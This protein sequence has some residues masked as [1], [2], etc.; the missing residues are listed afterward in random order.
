MVKSFTIKHFT[1]KELTRIFSSNPKKG[2]LLHK[3]FASQEKS[4]SG[5]WVKNLPAG[6]STTDAQSKD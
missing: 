5:F 2:M 3:C 6:N 4:S 1:F